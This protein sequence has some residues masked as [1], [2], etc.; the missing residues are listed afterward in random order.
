MKILFILKSFTA[1]GVERI[2]LTLSRM[3][4]QRGHE[5]TLAVFRNQG[6]LALEVP[7]EVR[8]RVLEPGKPLAGRALA[9]R[10]D[11]ASLAQMAR[12]VLLA[13]KADR[14][15][16][17]LSSLSRLFREEEPDAVVAAMPYV[18]LVVLWA[19]SLAGSRSR[20]LVMEHIEISRYLGA[21]SGW[22]HK[23]LLPLIRRSYQK[24][25]AIGA[26]SKGAAEDLVRSSG[27]DRKLV[28]VQ[29]NPVVTDEMRAMA[30]QPVEH[31]WFRTDAPP[32]VLTVGRLAEQKDHVTLLRAF[33]KARATRPLRLV[34]LG[35]AGSDDKTAERIS[36]L[37]G[38]ARDLG[39]DQD[40]LFAGFMSNPYAYMAK[41]AVFVLSSRYEGLPT[42][43]VEAMACG[44][45]VV[46]TACPGSVEI[47]G[48]GKYG[49]LVAIGDAE[50]LAQSIIA[51]LDS[52]PDEDALRQRSLDFS[53]ERSVVHY[54]SLLAGTEYLR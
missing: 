27:I 7:P 12:P 29:Y 52:E 25:E 44:C 8:L 15:L 6:P 13:A 45:P 49:Q 16:R 30:D 41:A 21:R 34:I 33:A 19:R 23:Y 50:A 18:N 20:V 28:R 17:Y 42:V 2:T 46:S 10:A 3:L 4:A 43:L 35:A 26:V 31:P 47:L 9:L 24:A 48:D 38:L 14:T 22:R 40:V 11:P 32:V 36:E 54:E 53:A 1:G 39:V 51:T 37:M 5:V